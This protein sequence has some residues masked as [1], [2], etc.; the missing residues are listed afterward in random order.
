MPELPAVETLRRGLST[1]VTGQRVI[2][3]RVLDG[4]ILAV[5]GEVITPAGPRH[6]PSDRAGE[7]PGQGADLL[8]GR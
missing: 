8:P 5:P 1:E 2:S 7:P 3:V 4:K 6:R